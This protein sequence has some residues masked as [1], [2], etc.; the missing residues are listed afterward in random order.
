M[1][2]TRRGSF[3]GNGEWSRLA[4]ALLAVGKLVPGAA[5]LVGVLDALVKLQRPD[6]LSSIKADTI[7][8]RNKD[9]K[10]GMQNLGYAIEVGPTNERWAVWM[11]RAEEKLNDALSVLDDDDAHGYLEVEFNLA[12][13]YLACGREDDACKRL[14]KS[15]VHADRA[16]DTYL[17]DRQW[18][19][20]QINQ[21]RMKSPLLD[22]RRSGA[23]HL[24][25]RQLSSRERA[26]G[27]GQFLVGVT[28]VGLVAALVQEPREIR[29]KERFLQEFGNFLE[30]YNLNEYL[31]STVTRRHPRYIRA[32][33]AAYARTTGAVTGMSEYDAWAKRKDKYYLVDATG[34]PSLILSQPPLR[35][36]DD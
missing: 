18:D 4:P 15:T 9:F 33:D 29:R 8:I 27:L 12:L 20:A 25:D 16:L 34:S 13:V 23:N 32:I 21:S 7:A 36:I 28:G 31:G 17:Q 19:F 14:G 22:D 5:G 24:E 11:R 3:S 26:A 10:A 6:T 35:I 30:L 2:Q 1:S